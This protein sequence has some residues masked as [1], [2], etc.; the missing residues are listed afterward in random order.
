DLGRDDRRATARG[1]SLIDR[2]DRHLGWIA[3][4]APELLDRADAPQ[5][6]LPRGADRAVVHDHVDRVG[7][8]LREVAQGD[9]TAPVNLDVEAQ[10]M[11]LVVGRY[12][13]G[14]DRFAVDDDFDKTRLALRNLAAVGSAERR[15]RRESDLGLHL[16]RA[17]LRE[18]QFV[19][20]RLAIHAELE[21]VG[22]PVRDV[23]AALGESF[24]PGRE[25]DLVDL[26]ELDID[27]P[28]AD[29]AAGDAGEIGLAAGLEREAAI[30]DVIPAVPFGHAVGVHGA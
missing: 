17:G 12:L 11:L 29:A 14:G 8:H 21:S 13:L 15:G 3:A 4:L 2:A 18:V 27:A 5:G 24:G 19:A 1:E 25:V 23:R 20:G 6:A 9:P 26:A 30:H 28:L 7:V 16:H 10:V 22:V